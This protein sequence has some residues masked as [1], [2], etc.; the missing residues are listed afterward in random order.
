MRMYEKGPYGPYESPYGRMIEPCLVSREHGSRGCRVRAK[1]PPYGTPYGTRMGRMKI[2]H[3]YGY[4]RMR[5]NI[6]Y[7]H[8][9]TVCAGPSKGTQLRV[10]SCVFVGLGVT[11][12]GF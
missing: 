6:P 9:H 5:M 3:S 11:C 10:F 12:V 8:T 1:P 2:R 7:G 4:D